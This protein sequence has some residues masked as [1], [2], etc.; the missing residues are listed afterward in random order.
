MKRIY[1]QTAWILAIASVF[2]GCKPEKEIFEETR[3]E[4]SLTFFSPLSRN[5]TIVLNEQYADR[6]VISFAWSEAKDRGADYSLTY[7]FRLDKANNNFKTAI[8]PR[9]MEEGV[10]CTAFTAEELN[11]YMTEKWGVFSGDVTELEARIVAKV[12][13]PKFL[14]PAIGLTKFKI[15]SYA[16]E[17]MPLYI[18]GDATDAGMEPSKAIRLTEMSNGKIYTW[19]G[20]LKRGRFKFI[21]D[22][23]SMF[24]S[25]NMGTD[26][27]TIVERNDESLP[28]DYFVIGENDSTGTYSFLLNLKKDTIIYKQVPYKQLYLIGNAC[29]A[30]WDTSKAIEFTTDVMNPGVFTCE[31]EL[32]A[33][34]LKILTA[35][36]FSG[37]CYRPIVQNGSIQEVVC[38]GYLGEQPDLKWLVKEEESG[39]YRIT[40]DVGLPMQIHFEKL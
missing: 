28:D 35:R 9:V 24:P 1:H 22:K 6:D 14:Y 39:T 25:Y 23:E 34:E 27:Y 8:D 18:V 20:R 38:Q 33:G 16:P 17:S 31:T 13:G 12:D 11:D 36:S 3:E 7:I 5:D 21:L 2:V 10:F 40:L 29:P 15:K 30:E 37:Y 4:L 32:T 26:R 19:E